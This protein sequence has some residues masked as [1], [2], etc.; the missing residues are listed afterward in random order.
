MPSPRPEL[1]TLARESRGYTQEELAEAVDVTQAAM[2]RVEGRLLAPSD[3][4]LQKIAARLDFPVS[5][6]LQEEQEFQV[7]NLPVSFFRRRLTGI[8]ARIVKIIRAN[9]TVMLASL[10]KLAKSVEFP[11]LRLPFISLAHRGIGPAIAAQEARVQL[12]MP[13]GPVPNMTQ[14]LESAGVLVLSFDFG[15]DRI[16]GMSLFDPSIGLPPVICVNR[17]MPGD[18]M[19]F[20][21]A[22]ELGHIVLHSHI[23]SMGENVDVEMEADQFAA[24]FLMPAADI[25]GHLMSV[26]YSSLSGLKL[27]WKTSMQALLVRADHLG[28]ITASQK[29]RIWKQISAHANGGR[30]NEANPLPREEP[31]LLRDLISLHENQLGY[32]EDDL[33]N[34]FHVSKTYLRFNY[35]VA[36][37]TTFRLVV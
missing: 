3:E 29:S 16:D 20:T 19:R 27:Y 24:E 35:P 22:H 36:K 17:D 34:V 37:A 5:F 28:L 12:K 25:T 31:R 15:T 32:S 21:L 9:W 4:L 6:F 33:C 26:S 14:A 1:I 18:R 7:N 23:P 10:R 8:P 11:E 30:T 2:S 13:L